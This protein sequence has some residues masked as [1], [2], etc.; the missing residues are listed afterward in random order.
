MTKRYIFHLSIPVAD[1]AAA[2]RFY[3]EVLG[4]EVGRENDEW[5]D[6]LLWGDCPATW[7]RRSHA[8]CAGRSAGTC[9]LPYPADSCIAV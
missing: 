6:I 8:C 9:A 3:V 1:L 7:T 2:R 4:A 5:L